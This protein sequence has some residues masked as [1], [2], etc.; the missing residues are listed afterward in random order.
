MEVFVEGD[1]IILQKYTPGCSLCG[2]T[3]QPLT[4][5]INDKLICSTC[6][7]RIVQNNKKFL[8]QK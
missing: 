2:N 4:P 7:E 8:Q 6:T 5:F 3:E 1:K